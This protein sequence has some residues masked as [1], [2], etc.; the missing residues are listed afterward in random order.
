MER[1]ELMVWEGVNGLRAGRISP[2]RPD[3]ESRQVIDDR[4]LWKSNVLMRFTHIP[5][6][7]T[8]ISNAAEL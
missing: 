2:H 8:F 6:I 1:T 7:N 4:M 3:G 5:T